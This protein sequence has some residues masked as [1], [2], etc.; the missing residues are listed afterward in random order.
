MH[1]ASKVKVAG[2]GTA[3]DAP[4][5]GSQSPRRSSQRKKVDS[6]SRIPQRTRRRGTFTLEEPPDL[7]NETAVPDVFG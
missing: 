5:E 6:G 3:A 4:P 1:G 7:G 2:E